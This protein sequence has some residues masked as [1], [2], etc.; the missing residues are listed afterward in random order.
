[1]KQSKIVAGATGAIFIVLGLLLI[2]TLL[3][4]FASADIYALVLPIV[5][6]MSGITT[7]QD[8]S[9]R[10]AGVSYGLVAIGIVMLLVRFDIIRGD[11]VNGLLGAVLLVAGGTTLNKLF[12]KPTPVDK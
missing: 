10:K 3:D 4:I 6:I 2:G 11:V 5:L 7:L 1:M 9:R 12:Q 8:S